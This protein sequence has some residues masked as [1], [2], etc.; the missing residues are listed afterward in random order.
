MNR[1]RG[2]R[3][4]AADTGRGEDSSGEA[5]NAGQSEDSG[6]DGAESNEDEGGNGGGDEGGGD[7][8]EKGGRGGEGG[9]GGSRSRASSSN[10]LGGCDKCLF[11]RIGVAGWVPNM[12]SRRPCTECNTLKLLNTDN[13][14]AVL[15]LAGVPEYMEKIQEFRSVMDKKEIKLNIFNSSTGASDDGCR[16]VFRVETDRNVMELADGLFKPFA[17]LAGE[18]ELYR[19]GSSVVIESKVRMC[20]YVYD[21]VC[22]LVGVHVYVYLCVCV[23]VCVAINNTTCHSLIVI[24]HAP[25]HQPTTRQTKGHSSFST[26]TNTAV[27]S[28]R[29][30]TTPPSSLSV[31]GRPSCCF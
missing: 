30:K 24:A 5:A 17:G 21:C 25:P 27:C 1:P 2:G 12:K 22:V 19:P 10:G 11:S 16:A 13:G 31:E 8:E 3:G 26:R 20:V 23:C 14:C 18:G 6:E 28:W 7:K 15:S 9:V 29:C 4:R